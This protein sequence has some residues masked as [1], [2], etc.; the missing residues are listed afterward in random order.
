MAL[1]FIAFCGS[2]PDAVAHH[3]YAFYLPQGFESGLRVHLK[4]LALPADL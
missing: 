4:S 3:F 2:F 1:A